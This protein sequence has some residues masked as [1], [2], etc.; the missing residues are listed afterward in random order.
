MLLARALHLF[1]PGKPQVWYLDLFAGKN[2]YEA[3]ARCGPGGHKEINRTNLTMEQ[4]EDGLQRPVVQ[5][6]LELL[7]WRNQFPAFGFDTQMEF[8]IPSPD[9]LQIIWPHNEYT[10]C[11]EANLRTSAF[12]VTGKDPSGT[13]CFAMRQ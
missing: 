4:I 2:D 1:M 11:L 13:E 6:Q 8:L 12:S 7:K 10:A 9:L 5:R 3:V